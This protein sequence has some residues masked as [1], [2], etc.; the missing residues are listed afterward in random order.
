[1]QWSASGLPSI[2]FH[3]CEYLCTNA[4]R[5]A[6]C[7]LPKVIIYETWRPHFIHVGLPVFRAVFLL[8]IQDL[9]FRLGAGQRGVFS[10]HFCHL[11]WV[12]FKQKVESR[13]C[14]PSWSQNSAKTA[15]FSSL[16]G[17][18]LIPSPPHLEIHPS[19]AWLLP[20]A[21]PHSTASLQGAK[22]SARGGTHWHHAACHHSKPW[23]VMAVGGGG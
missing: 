20:R 16:P 4:Q 5:K 7:F 14:L 3:Q 2:P 17:N 11:E 23:G 19:I 18:G 21:D 22:G 1:M 6:G 15:N 12:F 8:L 10:G 13:L 9:A